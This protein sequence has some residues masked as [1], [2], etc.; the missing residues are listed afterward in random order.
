MKIEDNVMPSTTQE[1]YEKAVREY[2][3][4]ILDELG[5]AIHSII[6]YGSAAIRRASKESDIDVLV[7]GEHK[8]DIERRVSEI[9]YDIDYD[10]DFETFITSL[11]MIV[12]DFQKRVKV[13]SPFIKNVLKE[14]VAIYDDGTFKRIRQEVFETGR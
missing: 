2:A 11:Y 12:I 8:G 1:L 13:G 14:G 6:L 3:K 7:I 5:N 4:R 10:Y 9:G